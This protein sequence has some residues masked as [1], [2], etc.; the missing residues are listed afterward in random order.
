MEEGTTPIPLFPKPIKNNTVNSLTSYHNHKFLIRYADNKEDLETM[1][2]KGP[3]DEYIQIIYD[4]ST[5]SLQVIRDENYENHSELTSY[6]NIYDAV[7][8]CLDDSNNIKKCITDSIF[9]QFKDLSEVK[10]S[11]SK[12]NDDI[13]LR[14]RNYS[15]ADPLVGTTEPKEILH[16]IIDDKEFDL[17]ILL[18]TEHAKIWAID[19]FITQEECNILESHG[20]PLLRRATVAAE[21][22][23]AIVSENRKAQ[24]ALYDLHRN[25]G[26]EDPL[27]DLQMRILNVVNHHAGYN[28][29]PDGQE[30]FTIIQYNAGDQYT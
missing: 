19:D 27:W 10:S 2:T 17:K 1:F 18:D 20:R 24:Q 3:S 22:G 15:C 21:D 11:I 25:R 26:E 30:G 4:S 12:L 9:P 7:S 14:L 16:Q 28:L 6:N 5:R 8:E 29:K 13:S 23:S